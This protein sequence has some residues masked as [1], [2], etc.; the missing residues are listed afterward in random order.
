MARAVTIGSVIDKM[1]ALAVKRAELSAKDKPLKE[2]YDKLEIE[3]I[4]L[5]REQ[6]TDKGKSQSVEATLKVSLRPKI[7]D[8]AELWKFVK[9]NDYFHLYYRRLNSTAYEEL[10]GINKGKPLP[11]TAIF[12]DVGISLRTVSS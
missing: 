5:M 3:L 7:T 11:G 9:K 4:K 2:E 1:K 8:D 12:E 6:N 10:V